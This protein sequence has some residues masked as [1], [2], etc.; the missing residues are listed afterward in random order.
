MIEDPIW[1][2]CWNESG[3]CR[4]LPTTIATEDA[5]AAVV[6][7]NGQ[8][9]GRCDGQAPLAGRSGDKGSQRRGV[10]RPGARTT[11]LPTLFATQL[12]GGT[13]SNPSTVQTWPRS[14]VEKGGKG[15]RSGSEEHGLRVGISLG[16]VPGS[17]PRDSEP[18]DAD[19][20]SPRG[21]RVA[22]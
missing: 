5:Q 3:L 13:E 11:G 16:K 2:A 1:V 17:T 14:S 4:Q 12:R 6:R 18:V 7:S 19:W 20:F 10:P 8:K 22:C 9:R 15:P 21:I